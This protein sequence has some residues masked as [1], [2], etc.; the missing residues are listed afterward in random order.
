M[1]HLC[2]SS[3]HVSLIQS[4]FDWDLYTQTHI[5]TQIFDN[6][7]IFRYIFDISADSTEIPTGRDGKGWGREK[8]SFEVNRRRESIMTECKMMYDLAVVLL[9][10][11]ATHLDSTIAESDS[12][13]AE[14]GGIMAIPRQRGKLT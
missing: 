1:C 6:E 3:L 12:T 13:M 5:H 11:E 10:K 7:T 9:V 4:F 14:G 8:S 2:M